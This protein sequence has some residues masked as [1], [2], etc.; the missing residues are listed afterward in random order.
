MKT[1]K[2]K[3]G[4]MEK[5]AVVTENMKTGY[6]KVCVYLKSVDADMTGAREWMRDIYT[7]A[8]KGQYRIEHAG[9]TITPVSTK[10]DAE[11][12][13]EETY[14]R[15][16]KTQGIRKVIHRKTIRSNKKWSGHREC[17][18]CK[19][20]NGKTTTIHNHAVNEDWDVCS[21]CVPKIK[22]TNK[23]VKEWRKK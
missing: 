12:Y 17:R 7:R 14:S 3:S 20:Q 19:E 23:V 5:I 9:V 4:R 18:L 21:T 1:T 13:D 2:T 22:I 8:M 6:M 15:Y 16:V 11:E 10:E